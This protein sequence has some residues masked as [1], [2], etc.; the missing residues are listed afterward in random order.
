MFT[1]AVKL[2]ILEPATSGYLMDCSFFICFIF[3]LQ[4][5]ATGPQKEH[6]GEEE[7][8]LVIEGFGS[9]EKELV[10]DLLRALKDGQ[11]GHR[12]KPQQ[13]VGR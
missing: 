3:Q 13:N 12:S 9:K 7:R 6:V 5:M 2:G 4:R 8:V 11:C 1:S 10:V